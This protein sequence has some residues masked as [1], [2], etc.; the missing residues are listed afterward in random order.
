M[1]IVLASFFALALLVY[2]IAKLYGK[3]NRKTR[4]LPPG[5]YGWP[6]LGET[7]DFLGAGVNGKPEN[8]LFDRR[9]KYKSQVFKTSMMG[10][11]MAVLCGPAGNKFL[12][13]NENKLVTVWWPSSVR[14]LLGPC[15]ATSGG[16]EGKQMRRMV[17]YFVTPD[18]FTRLYIKTMDLVSQQHINTHWLGK[19]LYTMSA[20]MILFHGYRDL[21]EW[22]TPGFR[23]RVPANSLGLP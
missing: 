10:E 9:D 11:R 16:D 3:A 2:L 6:I 13:S 7:I 20:E 1:I 22:Q 12:F 14:K 19:C 8:F 21:D 18:A 23:R 17:S 15:L 4:N 5:S